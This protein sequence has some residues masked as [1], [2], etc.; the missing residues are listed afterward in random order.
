MFDCALFII[1][2]KKPAQISEWCDAKQGIKRK[3]EEIIELKL[4]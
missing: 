1:C 4:S 3:E 2:S